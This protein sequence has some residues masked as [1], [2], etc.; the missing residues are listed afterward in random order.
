MQ[1]NLFWVSVA[2]IHGFRYLQIGGTLG[3][4]ICRYFFDMDMMFIQRITVYSV[5][6]HRNVKQPKFNQCNYVRNSYYQMIEMEMASIHN[7]V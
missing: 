7:G 6:L 2:L 4:S 1:K 3:K 5:I